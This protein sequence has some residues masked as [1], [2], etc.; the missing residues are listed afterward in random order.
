MVLLSGVH[1][2][3]WNSLL[4]VGE[5][6]LQNKYIRKKLIFTYL[7]LSVGSNWKLVLLWVFNVQGRLQL[8]NKLWWNEL[9]PISSHFEW[10]SSS[11]MPLD[12]LVSS[13][14]TMIKNKTVPYLTEESS[15]RYYYLKSKKTA[16]THITKVL[17]VFKHFWLPNNTFWFLD[18]NQE[19]LAG[20]VT[21]TVTH[22]NLSHRYLQR[23][24]SHVTIKL[25]EYYTA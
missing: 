4:W 20:A 16:W 7:G 10:L 23:N 22:Y 15:H 19:P 12:M 17:W 25:H 14:L 2:G 1:D 21:L 9:Y 3:L 5:W 13:L 18:L 8:M 11:Y 6:D 24:C